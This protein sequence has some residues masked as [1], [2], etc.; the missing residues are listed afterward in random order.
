MA[1]E[2]MD[3]LV[4]HL[5]RLHLRHGA[6]NLEDHLRQA[7]QLNLSH[8]D[9][10]SRLVDA[11]VLARNETGTAKRLAQA[12]FPE[13]LQVE[14]FDFKQQPCVDRKQILHLAELG[15]LDRCEA[16]LFIGPSGVGKSHLAIGLGVRACTAGYRVRFCRAYD[17]FKRL[18]ASLADNTLDEVLQELQKPSLLIIDELGN[19]PRTADQD[20]APVFFELVSRRYRRGSTVI[21]TNLGVDEWPQALGTPSLLAPTLDRLLD[22]AHIITFPKE[23]R[24]FRASRSQ[25]PGPLAQRRR[26]RPS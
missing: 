4:A 22:G 24:S 15:F 19:S 12:D 18:Y 17:L 8:F 2:E 25:G 5:K 21:T 26:G 1:T 7:T 10:L 9:F 16:V 6:N 11:E 3:R 23:A 14:S 13:P 20:F